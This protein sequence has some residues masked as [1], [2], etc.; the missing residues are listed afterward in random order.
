MRLLR[1]RTGRGPEPSLDAL[2]EGALRPL[3][4]RGVLRVQHRRR[5]LVPALQEAQ[6]DGVGISA[7]RRVSP[8]DE[9][10]RV[11]ADLSP[12]AT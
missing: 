10:A 11:E 3:R 12:A 6:L 8:L 4:V 7:V 9:P 5:D 2:S 1:D